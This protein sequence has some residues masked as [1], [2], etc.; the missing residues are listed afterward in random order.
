[1]ASRQTPLLDQL[2]REGF[3]PP[4]QRSLLRDALQRQSHPDLLLPPEPVLER[5]TTLLPSTPEPAARR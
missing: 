1:M 3:T 2:L 5:C 4:L